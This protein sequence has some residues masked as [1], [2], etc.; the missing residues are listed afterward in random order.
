MA[1]PLGGSSS[2]GGDNPS[3]SLQQEFD[4]THQVLSKLREN[5]NRHLGELS[6]QVANLNAQLEPML[7]RVEQAQYNVEMARSTHGGP[8]DAA[9][10]LRGLLSQQEGKVGMMA[11]MGGKLMNF[12]AD[13]LTD[14][15]LDDLLL[16]VVRDLQ[17]I[18]QKERQKHLS[19]EGAQFAEDLLKHVVD[20]QGEQHAVEL[21]WGNEAMQARAKNARN[22]FGGRIDVAEGAY[23]GLESVQS[24]AAQPKAMRLGPHDGQMAEISTSQS[25]SLPKPAYINPFDLGAASSSLSIN[26]QHILD[27]QKDQAVIDSQNS[28]AA[29]VHMDITEAEKTALDNYQPKPRKYKLGGLA[30]AQVQRIAKYKERYGQFLQMHNNSKQKEVWKIYDHITAELLKECEEEVLQEVVG[31]DIEKYFLEQVLIDEF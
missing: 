7:K 25:G 6:T 18:E 3:A 27:R 24:L 10:T 13:D 22:T 15:L 29:P 2:L 31:E 19:S 9:G 14:L 28:G 8:S 11:R 4:V 12:Y 21:R 23:A 5:P 30:P 20:F 1:Q 17:A 16:D 26:A